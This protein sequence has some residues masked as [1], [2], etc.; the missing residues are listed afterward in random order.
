ME[1]QRVRAGA[2]PIP[3]A[4]LG[5]V[6]ATKGLGI[7]A[8]IWGHMDY[9]WS[10]SSVWFSSFK[11]AVFFVVVG[12]LKARRYEARGQE[13]SCGSVWG[14]RLYSLVIPYGVYSL[15]AILAHL[16]FA[17]VRHQGMLEALRGDIFLTIT[18]RGIATLWFLPTLLLAELLFAAI[19]PESR[20][21]AVKLLLCILMP[22]LLWAVCW[23]YEG[24]DLPEGLLAQAGQNLF[25]VAAK[26]VSGCWFMLCGYY[27]YRHLD[28]KRLSRPLI[29]V[30][31][32]AVNLG[33]SLL[34][35][36]LDFNSF[37]LGRFGL[38]FYVNG[39]LGSVALLELLRYLEGRV[40]LR[41]LIWCG[42][43]SMFLM[44]THLPWQIAPEL[45]MLG[46]RFYLAQTPTAPYFLMMLA[47]FAVLMLIEAALVWCKEKVKAAMTGRWGK[48]RPICKAV[49]YL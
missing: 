46:K 40:S 12:L 38:V 3:S 42:R 20:S 44:A 26:S 19:R 35:P 2:G 6:D 13:E 30:V 43:H 45:L 29:L 5:F 25:V 22:V 15:L 37:R 17:A 24:M 48:E 1:E 10:T 36:K 8:V 21:R 11:L 31:L 16:A 32:L 23:F 9:L 39:V 28:P 47:E 41:P 4:H 34:S 14:K 18:L 7:L 49:K 33:L 27:I